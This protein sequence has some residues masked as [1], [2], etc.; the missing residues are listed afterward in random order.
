MTLIKLSKRGRPIR[1]T[2][3]SNLK[4]S[5]DNTEIDT[6]EALVYLGD[7]RFKLT[8]VPTDKNKIRKC[9]KRQLK[10]LRREYKCKGNTEKILRKMFPSSTVKKKVNAIIKAKSLIKSITETTG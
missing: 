4:V 6:I 2:T 3:R 7:K 5:N 10:W 9:N 1:L 8:F